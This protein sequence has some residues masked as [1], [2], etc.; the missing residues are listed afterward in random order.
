MIWNGVPN[1]ERL[2]LWKNL[3]AEIKELPLEVQLEK[4]A[5]FCAAMPYGART[6]DYYSS[7]NWPTPWEILYHGSFCTSSISLLIFYTLTLLSPDLD[8]SL[9]L[10][11]DSGDIFLLPVIDNHFVLNYELGEVSK[12]PDIQNRI[13]VLQK[14]SRHQVKTIT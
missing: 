6:L 11:N 5:K 1:D 8:V 14:Y 12:Y 13:E 9:Y 2:R 4:L 7:E 3:R 10:V